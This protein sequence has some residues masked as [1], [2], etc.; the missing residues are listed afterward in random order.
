MSAA[1]TVVTPCVNYLLIYVARMGID[2]AALANNVEAA[3]YCAMLLTYFIV[4]ERGLVKSGRHTW[5]GWCAAPPEQRPG[6]GADG[7]APVPCTPLS[8]CA[9]ASACVPHALSSCLARIFLSGHALHCLQLYS[10]LHLSERAALVP[11]S[12]L[13]GM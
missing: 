11:Q 12:C 2:G 7:P 5:H 13:D 1:L 10:S 4:K 6:P 3:L 8:S 9:V